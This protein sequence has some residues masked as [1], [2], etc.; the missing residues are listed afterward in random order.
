[1][2][3]HLYDGPLNQPLAGWLLT[4]LTLA[5][6]WRQPRGWLRMVLIAFALQ[7]CLDNYLTGTWNPLPSTS[8]LN[9]PLAILFV[10][11]GDW[12]FFLLTEKFNP[13]TRAPWL[14]SLGF[15]LIVPVAQGAATTLLP[16]AFPTLRHTFLAY[17][18]AFLSLAVFWRARVLLVRLNDAPEPTRRWLLALAHFEIA[19]YALWPLADVLILSGTD[20]GRE[21]GYALR[22]VPNTLYYGGFLAFAAWR[23]PSSA[24]DVPFAVTARASS[25]SNTQ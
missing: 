19:Q 11:L 9:Q 25:P 13:R 6:L 8:P 12:R 4:A 24:W 20:A 16:Q 1:M 2:W 22:L 18:L 17:E 15:A 23:A 10:I 7:L 5:W 3:Q 14:L 21:A